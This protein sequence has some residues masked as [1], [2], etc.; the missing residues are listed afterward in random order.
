MKAEDAGKQADDERDE[1]YGANM[2]GRDHRNTKLAKLAEKHWFEM[3]HAKYPDGPFGY[4][5]AQMRNRGDTKYVPT[6]FWGLEPI[7]PRRVT[8]PPAPSH[9][10]AERGFAIG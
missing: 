3:L 1:Y 2:N 8:A 7:D 10:F 9:V 5:L 4:F 6:L